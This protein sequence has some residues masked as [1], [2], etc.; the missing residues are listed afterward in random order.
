M[1]STVAGADTV[2]GDKAFHVRERAVRLA[3][4]HYGFGL[5]VTDLRQRLQGLYCRSVHVDLCRG[6]TALR[7][8]S[9][10]LL[11]DLRNMPVVFI[12]DP[13]REIDGGKLGI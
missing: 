13:S 11:S 3:V 4:C 5:D 12:Q 6:P 9:G 1:A 2:Y 10:L 7:D 8:L